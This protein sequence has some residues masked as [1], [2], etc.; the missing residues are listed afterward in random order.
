VIKFLYLSSHN[1][2]SL[3][4]LKDFKQLSQTSQDY[5]DSTQHIIRY[6]SSHVAYGL[7]PSEFKIKY[8]KPSLF[9]ESNIVWYIL[10]KL[11][12]IAR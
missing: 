6:N 10:H 8:Y 11:K 2:G 12:Y 3:E 9:R 4:I 7:H 5:S 1:S